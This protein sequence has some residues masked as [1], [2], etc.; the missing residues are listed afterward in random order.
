M[1]KLLY[2][3][4][5]VIGLMSCAEQFSESYNIHGSSAISLP[6]DNKFYLKVMKDGNLT[7]LNDIDSCVAVHG[8]FGFVGKLD[9]VRIAMISMREGSELGMPL[10]LEKG[11]IKASIEK[12]GYKVSGTPLNEILYDYIDKH[13][14]FTNQRDELDHKELQM[15]LDG[16]DD[17]AIYETLSVANNQLMGRIDSLETRFILENLDNVLGPYAFQMITIGFNYP[18]LTPQIEEIMGKATDKFK[19]DPYVSSYYAKAKEILARMKG[20][21]DDEGDTATTEEPQP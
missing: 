14:Q 3:I 2:I 4:T 15:M 21:I 18:V 1:K 7:E 19:N 10:V 11:D 20:E 9:S 5:G 6:D 16:Y 12:T 13:I 8:S 17:Q